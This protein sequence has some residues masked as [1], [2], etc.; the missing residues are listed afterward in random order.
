MDQPR[1][2]KSEAKKPELG[3]R[4]KPQNNDRVMDLDCPLGELSAEM[5]A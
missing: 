5:K 1:P 2:K 3:L 4:P